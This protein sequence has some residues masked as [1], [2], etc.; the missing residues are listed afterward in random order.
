MDPI[1]HLISVDPVLAR[2]IKKV[3]PLTWHHEKNYFKSL[4]EAIIN[5]QLSDK[6]AATITKRF[7]A[8]F[9][10]VIFPTPQQIL[11]MPDEKVRTAGISFQ[12][13]S[14]IKD[15]A[16]RVHNDEIDFDSFATKSD[17][18]VIIEL[19]KVK[20]IGRW[21]A[22]MFLMFSLGRQDVFSFGDLGLRK[23]LQKVYKMKKPPT[24]KQA[25]TITNKWKPFRTWGS[26]YLW[27]SLEIDEP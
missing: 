18:E 6:A 22:E 8:L 14:Y 13:I 3:A 7:V 12:K 5:Q 11:N 25:A 10:K 15:L 1:K 23:G 19:I 24:V 9:P 4:V 27:K 20:G 26:R 16:R 21:T 17:E 2:V